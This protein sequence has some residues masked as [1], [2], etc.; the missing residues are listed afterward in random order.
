METKNQNNANNKD[1]KS[2]QA[3]L[4]LVLIFGGLWV[5]SIVLSPDNT[6]PSSPPSN[7]E[8][9]IDVC[10]YSQLEIKTKLKDPS[11]AKFQ[12]CSAGS[13][14]RIEGEKYRFKSWVESN[15][16]FGAKVRNNFSC[17]VRLEK[18][19]SYYINCSVY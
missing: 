6:T 2:W 14:E 8:Y 13:Y 19:E 15:N 17:E 4:I 1:D 11:S 10:A 5:A 18:D 3:G 7:S 9:K 16:S 12:D